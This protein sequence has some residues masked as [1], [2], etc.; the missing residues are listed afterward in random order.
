MGLINDDDPNENFI[1]EGNI[2]Y[3]NS[4]NFEVVEETKISHGMFVSTHQVANTF[5][6]Q[7]A[8][9]QT[10]K[11][12]LNP[13]MANNQSIENAIVVNQQ[14][15]SFLRKFKAYVMGKLIKPSST[16]ASALVFIFAIL[17]MHCVYLKEQVEGWKSDPKLCCSVNNMKKM[18]QP[19]ETSIWNEQEKIWI[20]GIKCW[21]RFSVVLK[22]IGIFLNIS[23]ALCTMWANRVI[24][25]S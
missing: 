10:I 9:S 2:D 24:V 22:K 5:F 14:G 23:L 6:H 11:V 17:L 4:T 18:R 1:D 16:I 19:V 21:E 25:E 3:S 13:V 7:I 20:V 15:S 12:Q 8:P